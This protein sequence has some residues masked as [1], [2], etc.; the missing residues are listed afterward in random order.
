MKVL[1]DSGKHLWSLS[2]VS[3]GV[4]AQDNSASSND[5]IFPKDQIEQLP[6]RSNDFLGVCSDVCLNLPA[7]LTGL[8][9]DSIQDS[10]ENKSQSS[11]IPAGSVNI[12]QSTNTVTGFNVFSG[13]L[14]SGCLF[15][16]GNLISVQGNVVDIQDV[17]SNFGNTCLSCASF[18]ALKLKGLEEV[19]IS[20]CIPVLVNHDIV[21]TIPS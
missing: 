8:L 18:D 5:G 9:E 14:G 12:S 21:T 20:F 1:V 7:H 2:C 17:A 19:A 16:E 13:S 6:L 3:D 4:C 10:E 15:P 11:I